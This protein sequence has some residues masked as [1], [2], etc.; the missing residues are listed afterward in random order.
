MCLCI[1]MLVYPVENAGFLLV[2][3]EKKAVDVCE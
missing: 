1:R 3:T 2:L